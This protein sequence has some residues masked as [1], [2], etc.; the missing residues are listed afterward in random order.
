MNRSA[1]IRDKRRGGRAL[2]RKRT[3][4]YMNTGE[5][6]ASSSCEVTGRGGLMIMITIVYIILAIADGAMAKE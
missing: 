2:R 6:E 3:L 4:R 5:M 1:T